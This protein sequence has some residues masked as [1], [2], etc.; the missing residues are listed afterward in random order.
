ML[1][2]VFGSTRYDSTTSLSSETSA[3]GL[4]QMSNNRLNLKRV[5]MSTV[6][7]LDEAIVVGL[8]IFVLSRF[9]IRTPIWVV[10]LDRFQFFP[11][12]WIDIAPEE[13]IGTST[14]FKRP[15][16]L[17]SSFVSIRISTLKDLYD[18]VA[19]RFAALY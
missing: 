9:G 17:H 15:A 6:S 19:D 13:F 16:F 10:V 1:S 11:Q 4:T 7:L 18:G 14:S 2:A 8:V 12:S 5:F 3:R